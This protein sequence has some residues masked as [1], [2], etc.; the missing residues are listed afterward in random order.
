MLTA[1][2]VLVEVA[3]KNPGKQVVQVV[4]L[5]ETAQFNNKFSQVLVVVLYKVPVGHL[6]T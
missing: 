6:Q 1:V 4:K 5:L 2:Q 3:Q